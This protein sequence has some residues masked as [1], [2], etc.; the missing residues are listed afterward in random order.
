[1]HLLTRE[2]LKLYLN[3]LAPGGVIAIHISNHYMEIE[4]VVAV[5]ARELGLATRIR[6]DVAITPTT[7]V[8]TG[9]APSE[10]VVLARAEKD[11]GRIAAHARWVTPRTRKGVETWTDDFSNVVE[12]LKWR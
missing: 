12:I 5:A 4:P 3:V 10:W 6:S 7:Q 11:L 8:T 9:R 2:A 1:M